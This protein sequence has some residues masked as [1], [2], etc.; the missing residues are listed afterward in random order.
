MV[1]ELTKVAPS[2]I[3]LQ[4]AFNDKILISL[5]KLIEYCSLFTA[6]IAGL[7]LLVQKPRKYWHITFAGLFGKYLVISD[8]ISLRVIDPAAVSSKLNTKYLHSLTLSI[9]YYDVLIY[10]INFKL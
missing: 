2:V 10:K 6:V 3:K 4:H 9:Q 5:Q 7:C 1:L 8:G